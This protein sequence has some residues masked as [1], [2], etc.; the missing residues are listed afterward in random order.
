MACELGEC[1][2]MTFYRRRGKRVLDV[3]VASAAIATTAP[4]LAAIALMT[5]CTAGSP[6]LFRDQ[7]AGFEGAP[8]EILK[9]RTM[10]DGLGPDGD[11]TTRLGAAL[12]ATSLDELPQLWNVLRGEMSIVGPRPLPVRYV[13]RY[14]PEQAR[15][16]LVRPGLTGLAQ[17]AGRNQLDW[18][19]RFELDTEYVDQLGLAVDLRV[20]CRTAGQVLRMRNV[21]PSGPQGHAMPE[22]EGSA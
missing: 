8:F 15:R 18:E 22:F 14:S 16:L 12:R 10:R 5:R 4:V 2:H 9:I 17:T 1:L 11:R 3:L 20:M 6:V 19:S 7:R 21:Q 13:P